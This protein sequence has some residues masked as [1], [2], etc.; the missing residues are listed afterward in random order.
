MALLFYQHVFSS[1]IFLSVLSD[2][3]LMCSHIGSV[4]VREGET[5]ADIFIYIYIIRSITLSRKELFYNFR[6]M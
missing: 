2:T 4:S 3:Y 5:E 1:V 6:L